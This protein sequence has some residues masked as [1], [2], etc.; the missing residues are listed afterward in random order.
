M[1]K[2]WKC[3]AWRAISTLY[4]LLKRIHRLPRTVYMKEE[5]QN[6]LQKYQ[7]LCHNEKLFITS[8]FQEN[9]RSMVTLIVNQVRGKSLPTDEGNGIMISVNPDA[10]YFWK[11]SFIAHRL[12]Q[13][14]LILIIAKFASQKKFPSIQKISRAS[15]RLYPPCN[16]WHAIIQ[17]RSIAPLLNFTLD[18]VS[19]II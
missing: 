14:P 17:S 18:W 11:F 9:W 8:R 12:W 10:I 19:D 13:E 6:R 15:H 4:R 1:T 3:K 7:K 2:F 16:K 5:K